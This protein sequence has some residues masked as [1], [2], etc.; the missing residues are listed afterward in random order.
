MEFTVERQCVRGYL[1]DTWGLLIVGGEE[2]NH[3]EK[4]FCVAVNIRD[5]QQ[6][7]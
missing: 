7:E 4:A 6:N 3:I 2:L 5:W 1:E